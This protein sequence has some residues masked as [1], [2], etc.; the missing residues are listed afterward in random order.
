MRTDWV[1]ILFVHEPRMA[2][3]AAIAQ[4][5]DWLSLQKREGRA[6]WLGLSG[7][8]AEC[9]GVAKALPGVFEVLQVE[10]SIGGKEADALTHAGRPLQLTY[11]Y[12][13]RATPDARRDA[14][15]ILAEA[16][17]RNPRGTVLVS[18]RQAA[19]VREMARVAEDGA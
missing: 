16:L 1:D 12:V 7:I 10:D 19:R 3:V 14:P 6:R 17:Q 8:A 4:L 13:R 2:E 18:S 5:S 15:R 11:G 9:V